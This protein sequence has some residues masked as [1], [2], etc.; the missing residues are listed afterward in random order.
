M[1]KRKKTRPVDRQ[2]YAAITM[3]QLN[4][5]VQEYDGFTP[6]RRVSGR[7]PKMAIGSVDNPFFND[8]TNPEDSPVAQTHQVLAKLRDIRK[9]SLEIDF[10][11]KFNRTLNRLAQDMQIDEFFFGKLFTFIRKLKK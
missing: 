6:V 10:N 4:S 7:A 2:G 8:F 9:S 3:L 5:Q 1:R 11:E